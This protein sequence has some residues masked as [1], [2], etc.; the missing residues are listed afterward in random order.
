MENTCCIS[1]ESACKGEWSSC[2]PDSDHCNNEVYM[3]ISSMIQVQ[4]HAYRHHYRHTLWQIQPSSSNK[5]PAHPCAALYCNVTSPMLVQTAD[6]RSFWNLSGCCKRFLPQYRLSSEL[7]SEILFNS[8]PLTLFFFLLS[9][10]EGGWMGGGVEEDNPVE[11][12]HFVAVNKTEVKWRRGNINPPQH[13]EK[14]Y[15]YMLIWNWAWQNN[16]AGGLIIHAV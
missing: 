2:V 3:T 6:R 1:K 9:G 5:T 13:E 7:L 4:C 15:G 14:E 8:S 10:Q 12:L 11:M 16:W